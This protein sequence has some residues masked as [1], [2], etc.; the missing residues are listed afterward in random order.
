MRFF[1][2]SREEKEFQ[3][4][5]QEQ[6]SEI[7]E[8]VTECQKKLPDIELRFKQWSS[9][10]MT[11]QDVQEVSRVLDD[12]KVIIENCSQALPALERVK[13]EVELPVEDFRRIKRD[14][15]YEGE[16]PE[17]IPSMDKIEAAY[18]VYERALSFIRHIRSEQL[19]WLEKALTEVRDWAARSDPAIEEAATR[20]REV[21]ARIEELERAHEVHLIHSRM[22][23][24]ELATELEKLESSREDRY[25]KG[26]VEAAQAILNLAD[27]GLRAAEDGIGFMQDTQ[28]KYLEARAALD[29]LRSE[30]R[31]A[32][33]PEPF[34]LR[35]GEDKLAAAR[36]IAMSA[37][38][39]W[40]EAI[41]NYN[42]AADAY[43]AA[44]SRLYS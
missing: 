31:R 38:P 17:D 23:L 10:N 16:L 26:T 13:D 8:S 1:G 15:L 19:P 2:L 5:A 30:F 43:D 11:S 7:L 12:V 35:E 6:W 22:L 18:W 36:G 42:Q 37:S 20:A 41:L 24:N 32:N 40:E 3:R 9:S 28:V 21:K 34:D 25:H 14:F 44:M 39:S 27:A 4:Q 33:L 29:R